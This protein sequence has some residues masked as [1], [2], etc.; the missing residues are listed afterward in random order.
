MTGSTIKLMARKVRN[1]DP[2]GINYESGMLRSKT[3]VKYGYFEARVKMPAGIGMWPAFWLNA[4]A[5]GWPPEIDIFEFVNN[6]RDDRADMLHTGVIDHGAQGSAFLSAVPELNK[7]WT[8]WTAP[9]AF[10]DAFHTV[11]CLWDENSAT[12]YVDGTAIVSRGYTW[13]H[14]DRATPATRTSCSISRWAANGQAATASMTPRS[15]R[16]SRSTTCACTSARAASTTC[17]ARSGRTCARPEASAEASAS[18]CAHFGAGG[19]GG[20]LTVT[21]VVTPAPD[22]PFVNENEESMIVP[23]PDVVSTPRRAGILLPPPRAKPKTLP[24]HA[25]SPNRSP[26]RMP[27]PFE[28]LLPP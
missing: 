4:E 11:A 3:I 21:L 25:P 23:A 6:G 28:V 17:R 9:Y 14:D 16:R 12:T 13:V 7:Q 26:W 2:D 18:D 24:C 10:P 22:Q 20:T 15:R 5:G 27:K 1:D 19:G 8:F